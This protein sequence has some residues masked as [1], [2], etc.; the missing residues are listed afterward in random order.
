MSYYPRFYRLP[1]YI[2]KEIRSKYTEPFTL[3]A[4]EYG[5]KLF[6]EQVEE[7]IQTFKNY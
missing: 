2:Q 4:I 5:E 3:E 6:E 7:D 1:R